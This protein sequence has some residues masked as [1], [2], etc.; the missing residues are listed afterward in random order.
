MN[1]VLIKIGIAIL[2]L[3]AINVLLARFKTTKKSDAS[4]MN[5]YLDVLNNPVYKIKK[6]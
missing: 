1:E 2:G 5:E 4:F 3:I 6:E